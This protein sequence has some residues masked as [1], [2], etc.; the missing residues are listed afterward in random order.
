MFVVYNAE[1]TPGLVRVLWTTTS[2]RNI[3]WLEDDISRSDSVLI[4]GHQ[5]KRFTVRSES[6]LTG[7]WVNPFLAYN[8]DAIEVE[9]PKSDEYTDVR[10]PE[11]P[12]VADVEWHP[13]ETDA[14]VVND[15]DPNFSIVEL[16]RN[17]GNFDHFRNLFK[18]SGINT[19]YIGG[20]P[21]GPDF[22]SLNKWHREFDPSAFGSYLRTF[23]IIA[24]GDQKTA[25]RFTVS[26]PNAGPWNLEYYVPRRAFGPDSIAIE[27]FVGLD[28]YST[29]PADTNAPEEHYTLTI[30][31]GDTEWDEEFNIANANIGWNDVREFELSSTEVEVLVSAWAGHKEVKVFADAIR[32]TPQFETSEN[33]E[34]SP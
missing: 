33:E 29:R 28:W 30:R 34:S 5:A 32:W 8:R 14:L 24:G 12:F 16:D 20:L 1:P 31:D 4:A 19:V 11:F 10:S 18:S 21:V 27:T 3:F 25:A 7:V 17:Q 9:L 15:L 22:V 26:L 6:P 13:P 23:A 2:D